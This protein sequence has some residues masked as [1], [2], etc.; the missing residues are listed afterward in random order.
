MGGATTLATA[1]GTRRCLLDAL[2]AAGDLEDWSIACLSRAPR[3]WP[4]CAPCPL[5]PPPPPLRRAPP[6]WDPNNGAA[7]RG[8]GAAAAQ[9][10]PAPLMAWIPF[11]PDAPRHE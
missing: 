1:R 3:A 6:T 9:D 11:P 2:N 10:R 5:T 4:T 7:W 8:A